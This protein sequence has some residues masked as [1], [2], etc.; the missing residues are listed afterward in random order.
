[1][2]HLFDPWMT[3]FAKIEPILQT[4][5]PSRR[6]SYQ[7]VQKFNGMILALAEKRREE[8]LEGKDVYTPDQEKDLMTLLIQVG[9]EQGI[10][11]TNEELR[12]SLL[13]LLLEIIQY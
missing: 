8:I 13:P 6:R 9:M 2:D 10:H 1:M 5:I 3:I 11:T 4:V 7:A 12:V